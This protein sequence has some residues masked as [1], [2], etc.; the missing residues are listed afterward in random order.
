MYCHPVQYKTSPV[1]ICSLRSNFHWIISEYIL[2]YWCSSKFFVTAAAEHDHCCKKKRSNCISTVISSGTEL[3]LISGC[4]TPVFTCRKKTKKNIP[5][6]PLVQYCRLML[7]NCIASFNPFYTHAHTNTH[8]L[9]MGRMGREMFHFK[10]V[11]SIYFILWGMI[12]FI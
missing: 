9:W 5:E 3:L 4:R 10:D 8:T 12:A 11:Y 2:H 1:W 6:S 7:E